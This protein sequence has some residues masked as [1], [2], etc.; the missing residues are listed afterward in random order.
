VGI[1]LH[2]GFPKAYDAAAD[3]VENWRIVPGSESSEMTAERF[4]LLLG[5]SMGLA[6]ATA[7]LWFLLGGR[8]LLFL[9]QES[10]ILGLA[11]VLLTLVIHELIHFLLLPKSVSERG[12]GV[13]LLGAFVA[14]RGK[15][16]KNRAL[17][18]LLGPL[19]V[20][21]GGPLLWQLFFGPVDDRVVFVSIWNTSL[22][23]VDLASACVLLLRVPSGAVIHVGSGPIRY[24]TSPHVFQG[25]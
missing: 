2:I 19:I 11:A 8:W 9:R 4:V 10:E 3:G 14:V 25:A 16:S 15:M 24:S 7:T 23:V 13:C 1:R 5:A 6:A 18:V 22:S 20:L 12:M 17:L 21:T